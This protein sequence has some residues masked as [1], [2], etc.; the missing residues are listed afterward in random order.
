MQRLCKKVKLW[1][2]PLLVLC[3][4]SNSRKTPLP[5]VMLLP[6]W[7]SAAIC[8]WWREGTIPVAGFLNLEMRRR[9]EGK[10]VTSYWGH[11]RQRRGQGSSGRARCRVPAATNLGSRGWSM[12]GGP[13]AKIKFT[14]CTHASIWKK[15]TRLSEDDLQSQPAL[16][17]LHLPSP[18]YRLTIG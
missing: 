17:Y 12:R 7:S 18:S 5:I 1:F 16:T 15:E 9:G 14:R 2:S 10:S 4:F 11:S 13:L 3:P 6:L 8:H